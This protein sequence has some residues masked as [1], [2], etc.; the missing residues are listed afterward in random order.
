MRLTYQELLN[1]VATMNK[2]MQ[3]SMKNVLAYRLFKNGKAMEGALSVYR[4]YQQNL[5]AEYIGE[6][7]KIPEDKFPEY[8]E[9]LE[10]TANE[11][12]LLDIST[13]PLEWL[14]DVPITPGDI[15]S[16]HYMIEEE[17]ENEIQEE[18]PSKKSNRRRSRN[19]RQE[20]AAGE[21]QGAASSGD[22]ADV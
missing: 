3:T 17:T 11:E 22:D 5:Q 16:I 8:V 12:V 2:L 18:E 9:K 1:S 15:G 20:G 19:K 6:D 21:D 14:D 4:E 10:E 13:F 7:D